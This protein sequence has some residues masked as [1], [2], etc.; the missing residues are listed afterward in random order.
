MTRYRYLATYFYKK[1]RFPDCAEEND[2][3]RPAKKK[4][5][6]VVGA[7]RVARYKKFSTHRTNAETEGEI[8]LQTLFSQ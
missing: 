1:F 6:K 8:P 2:T 4:P 5:M 7:I 3:G